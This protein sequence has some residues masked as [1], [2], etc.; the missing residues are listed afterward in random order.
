[1][2]GAPICESD[3][4][5]PGAAGNGSRWADAESLLTDEPTEAARRRVRR[6]LR[7]RIGLVVAALL[8]VVAV[9]AVMAVL[10]DDGSRARPPDEPAAGA[11]IWLVLALVGL[12]LTLAGAVLTWRS[13]RVPN[14]WGN[15]L[16]ALRGAERRELLAQ[17]GGRR[18][19]DPAR[20]PLARDL[21]TRVI[22]QRWMVLIL[23]GQS[24]NVLGLWLAAPTTPKA[25]LA[26]AALPL[27]AGGWTYAEW[28]ARR[29]RRFLAAHP[30]P[31][32]PPA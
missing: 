9:V 21:A 13:T 31:Q 2:R 7:M 27:L 26:V 10:S 12:V 24:L 28:A 1:V 20:L 32:P 18:P 14:G 5:E 8:V 30:A 6:T 16:F 19:V 4:V 25:V 15:P 22:G 23:A 29:A 17:I 3:T 11:D